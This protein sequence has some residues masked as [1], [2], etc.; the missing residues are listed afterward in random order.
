[1]WNSSSPKLR[2]TQCSS[3]SRVECDSHLDR[4]PPALGLG[5][6][7]PPGALE[8]GGAP[9]AGPLMATCGDETVLVEIGWTPWQPGEATLADCRDMAE[10]ADRSR[11]LTS[12]GW[13]PWQAL[14]VRVCVLV[15]ARV[16]AFVRLCV[17]VR[18]CSCVHVCV[19][20]CACASCAR[21]GACVRACVC[22]R[23]RVCVRAVRVCVRV[24]ACV[25]VCGRAGRQ[26]GG[27]ADGFIRVSSQGKGW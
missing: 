6:G 11:H 1:M 2:D 7:D 17:F 22:A 24:C 18:A 12:S 20:A 27:Q 9:L 19:R 16:R 8:L 23:V 26:V 21:V 25:G 13:T 15:R 3:S 5:G 4:P 10:P 14:C